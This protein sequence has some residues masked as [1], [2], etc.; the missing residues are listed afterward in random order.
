MYVPL[1]WCMLLDA[2][3]LLEQ[4]W[5]GSACD[6]LSVWRGGGAPSSLFPHDELDLHMLP[7]AK[8]VLAPFAYM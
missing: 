3:V 5:Q 8:V 2:P 4:P 7:E 1:Q 6:R